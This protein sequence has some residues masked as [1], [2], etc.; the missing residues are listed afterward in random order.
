MTATHRLATGAAVVGGLAWSLDTSIITIN[1]GAFGIPDDALYLT[2]LFTIAAAALLG[3]FLLAAGR[4]L[5]L[6]VVFAVMA[7]VAFMAVAT[8]ID[9][10]VRGLVHL[11]YDGHN[12]GL[13]E[14]TGLMVIGLLVLATGLF[15][16]RSARSQAG[17]GR[18]LEPS[19]SSSPTLT[20]TQ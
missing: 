4:P 16:S 10:G 7:F 19:G 6:R 5:V 13:N 2:G 12:R 18:P 14:E 20:S 3:G 11:I 9:A 17:T 8:G 15:G 1:N